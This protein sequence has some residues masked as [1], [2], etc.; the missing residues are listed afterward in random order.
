MW[1]TT[2]H[3]DSADQPP[4]R[5]RKHWHKPRISDPEVDAQS[6]AD[7][8]RMLEQGNGRNQAVHAKPNSPK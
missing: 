7:F 3:G 2:I 4:F 6:S 5:A 8:K 1:F